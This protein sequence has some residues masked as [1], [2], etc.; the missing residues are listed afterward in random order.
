MAWAAIAGP[1]LGSLVAGKGAKQAAQ[2]AAQP[3]QNAINTAIQQQNALRNL[4]LQM[5]S[6]TNP[7]T[8]AA[9]SLAPYYSVPGADVSMFTPAALAGTPATPFAGAT[10]TPS[11]L[12]PPPQAVVSQPVPPVYGTWGGGMRMPGIPRR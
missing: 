2:A 3:Y 12:S 8:Q 9:G 7:F 6:Q 4:I 1:I 11:W 5:R 10:F